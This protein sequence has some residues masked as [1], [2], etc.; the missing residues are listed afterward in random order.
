MA[1]MSRTTKRAPPP[2]K[3]KSARPATQTKKAVSRTKKSQAGQ[4]GRSAKSATARVAPLLATS[5]KKI[6]TAKDFV[7]VNPFALDPLSRRDKGAAISPN[8][9]PLAFAGPWMRLCVQM[10]AG[11]LALQAHLART[12][13]YPLL[14]TPRR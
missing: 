1:T 11:N 6:G 7:A 8:F 9:D 3:K 5:Q 10:V 12:A 13:I 4:S 2:G 14:A